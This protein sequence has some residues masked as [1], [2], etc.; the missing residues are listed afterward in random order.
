LFGAAVLISFLIQ[1]PFYRLMGIRSGDVREALSLPYQ[2][3]AHIYVSERDHLNAE[4]LGNISAYL[5][6]E[7]IPGAFNPRFADPVKNL[8]DKDTLSQTGL[9]AFLSTYTGLFLHYPDNCVNEFLALNVSSWYPLAIGPDEIAG[10]DYI[11]TFI[12]RYEP[13]QPKRNSLL[14]GLMELLDGIASFRLLEKVPVINLLCSAA[15]PVWILLLLLFFMTECGQKTAR[16]ILLPSLFLWA[17][18]LAGPVTCIRYIYPL[19][20]ALPLQIAAF[21][22]PQSSDINTGS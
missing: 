18:Y 11:E 12:A 10:R 8:A 15:T 14:P 21:L 19:M 6:T 7:K 4:D 22:Y 13:A 17:T 1:G 2:Q 20:L 9:P 16:I 5:D 3:M